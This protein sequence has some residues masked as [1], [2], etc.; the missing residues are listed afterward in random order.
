MHAGRDVD[1]IT[2]FNSIHVIPILARSL[3]HPVHY[4]VCIP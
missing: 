1:F 3:V 4:K 2:V